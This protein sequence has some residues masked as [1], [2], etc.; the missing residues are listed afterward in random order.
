MKISIQISNK[1]INMIRH[2]LKENNIER[3]QKN[4]NR[5]VR[6]LKNEFKL[7]LEDSVEDI[8]MRFQS[9][10]PSKDNKKG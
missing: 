1:D 7:D 4:I 3:S 6:E 5:V 2:N 8:A 9:L 10:Y